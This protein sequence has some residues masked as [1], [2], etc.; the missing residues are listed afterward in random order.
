MPSVAEKAQTLTLRVD[1]RSRVARFDGVRDIHFGDNLIII[2]DGVVGINPS[3]IQLWIWE[4]VVNPSQSDALAQSQDFAAVPGYT[5]RAQTQI[6]FNYVKMGEALAAAPVGTPA[7][8]RL[9]LRDGDMPFVDMDVDVYP[10]PEVGTFP[11]P[12]PEVI[13]T[14]P[15]VRRDH[16]R[17]WALDRLEE[18]LNNLDDVADMVTAILTK[19]SDVTAP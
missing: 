6:S 11:E 8:F 12:N 19:L 15:Y 3:D 9:I 13:A 2:V 5:S 10:N 17:Q 16:L 7:T 18:P 1:R 14:N 4:K